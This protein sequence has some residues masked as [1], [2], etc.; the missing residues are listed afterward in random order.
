LLIRP[1]HVD[2]IEEVSAQWSNEETEPTH[3]D[4]PVSFRALLNHDPGSVLV[5]ELDGSLVGTVIAGRD[6]WR[7]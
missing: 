2:D 3:T 6:G 5:A 4:N 1:G 7:G